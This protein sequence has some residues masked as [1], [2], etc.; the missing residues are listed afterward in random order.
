MARAAT[1]GLNIALNHPDPFRKGES[2]VYP[3]HGVGRIERIGFE[4]IAGYRLNFIQVSFDENQ[5]TLRVPLARARGAGL[6]KLA[7]REELAELLVVLQGRPRVSRLIWAKRAQEYLAKINSGHLQE[8]VEVVRDL[9]VSGDGSGGSFSQRNLFELALNRLA[10]EFAAVNR[11]EKA[12]AIGDLTQALLEART[13][14]IREGG[15]DPATVPTSSAP[16]DMPQA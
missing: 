10:A 3:T 16:V 5:M 1:K 11:T 14:V 7:T 6:R 2:V 15:S 13:G 12:G 4:E 8:L 9:Q